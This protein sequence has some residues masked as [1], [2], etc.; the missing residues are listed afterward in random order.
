MRSRPL[1]GDSGVS[2]GTPCCHAHHSSRTQCRR[3]HWF[4]SRRRTGTQKCFQSRRGNC[5]LDGGRV[6]GRELEFHQAELVDGNDAGAVAVAEGRPSSL[7][8][9]RPVSI[10]ASTGCHSHSTGSACLFPAVNRMESGRGVDEGRTMERASGAG[11]S[12]VAV[13]LGN[14]GLPT[15]T[16]A[17]HADC[18]PIDE[19]AVD[20]L[21]KHA[22]VLGVCP[23]DG[24][25]GWASHGHSSD[26]EDGEPSL[27]YFVS[28]KRSTGVGTT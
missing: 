19:W 17:V 9:R 10:P 6:L 20:S 5:R 12:M 24:S 8:G 14:R 1:I 25:G 22:T 2:A 4:C 13:A 23:L 26:L 28:S 16:P 7:D 11:F 18:T 3:R 15:D 27:Q 21:G